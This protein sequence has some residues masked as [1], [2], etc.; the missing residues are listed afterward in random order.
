MKVGVGSGVTVAVG[1]GGSVEVAADPTVAVATG[2]S[3]LTGVG[4]T[5]DAR[6]HAANR[7]NMSRDRKSAF[8][9][10]IIAEAAGCV[11]GAK[12]GALTTCAAVL[13]S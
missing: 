2:K 1:L 10:V 6:L 11:N 13:N 5:F 8:M 3:V 12:T 9:C 7:I 4:V